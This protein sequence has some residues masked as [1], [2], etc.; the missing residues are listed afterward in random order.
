MAD[1]TEFTTD[2]D[3]NTAG[4][5]VEFFNNP[6]LNGAPAVARTDRHINA[7]HGFGEGIAQNEISARWNGYFTPGA[8]GEHL[9]FVQ[10]PG[11]GG[12]YRLYVDD[13]LVISNWERVNALVSQVRMSLDARPHKIRFECFAHWTWGG[14]GARVGIVR[15]ETLVNNQAKQL[16]SRSDAVVLAVG[17]SPDSESEGGDR[18]FQLPPGQEELINAIAAANKNTVVVVTAGGAV[19]T[20]AWLNHVP[21]LLQSWY[22]G[23]EGGT[24]LAQLLFGDYSPSGKLPVSWERRW[25][26]SAVHDSYYPTGTDRKVT[27]SEGVF[28]GYRHFDK[29][30]VKPLFPFGYGLS[31]TTFSYKDLCLSPATSSDEKVTVSFDVTNTGKREGAEVA[32]VYVGD[33][34]AS[35]PRPLKELKGF[36]K[37]AL[38]PG[39]T[40]RVSVVLNR[41]AF[42]Y[43]DVGKHGWIV[44]PGTFDLYVARSA[45]DTE[46]TGK[47]TPPTSW[48]A[49]T[50]E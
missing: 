15:P 29:S 19:D 28:L 47:V 45:G 11:E 31:Y 43:Y 32:Q 12:G 37:V 30:G 41:R 40:K 13:K 33:R 20:N 38:R 49:R 9:L 27:Y 5:K 44:E 34:H 35:V 23:Q 50:G 26:D 7:E 36:A 3:G 22:S 42:S 24:A 4:L 17:F 10:G 8:P 6:N 25:E 16:A 39:E 1:T 48:S 2:T 21:A 14:P 46:L 18:T